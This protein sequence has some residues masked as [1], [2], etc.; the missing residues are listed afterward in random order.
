MNDEEFGSR[1]PSKL[2]YR[3]G[4]Q[5][6][7]T[8]FKIGSSQKLGPRSLICRNL[9]TLRKVLLNNAESL[10]SNEW[11]RNWVLRTFKIETQKGDQIIQTF[12]KIVFPQPEI[13][14]Y[15]FNLLKFQKPEKGTPESC[16][17]HWNLMNDEEFESIKFL[18]LKYGGEWGLIIQLFFRIDKQFSYSVKLVSHLTSLE[19]GFPLESEAISDNWRKVGTLNHVKYII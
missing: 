7:Q 13:R 15:L 10:K 14:S 1:K 4:D 19:I 5:I 16:R 11:W 6:I 8:F 18:K 2:K 9:T 17:M 12:C 3:R